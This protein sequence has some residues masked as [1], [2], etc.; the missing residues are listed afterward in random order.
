MT[1]E[2]AGRVYKTIQLPTVDYEN[3]PPKV[4]SAKAGDINSRYIRVK[5]LNQYGQN[6]DYSLY[7]YA[8]FTATLPDGNVGC[9]Q[10]N[11]VSIINGIDNDGYVEIKIPLTVISKPGKVVCEVS[12][13]TNEGEDALLT[14]RKFYIIVSPSQDNVSQW[15]EDGEFLSLSQVLNSV[16]GVVDSIDDAEANRILA[17]TERVSQEEIRVSNE[18][19]RTNSEN[20]RNSAESERQNK[21]LI[22]TSNENE[23][24]NSETLRDTNEN[25]R[26]IN[27]TNRQ[28]AENLRIQA[29]NDRVIAEN[30]RVN[31]LSTAIEMSEELIERVQILGGNIPAIVMRNNNTDVA[32]NTLLWVEVEDEI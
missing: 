14:S 31:A 1:I 16:A 11:N 24:I 9:A 27:E 26:Q 10:Q 4:I 8:S 23:R 13:S 5:F 21:E 2:M 30:A 3:T 25:A 32:I 17:E 29:E 20:L 6:I 28:N 19:T 7:N 18:I 22:R 12:L 15:L